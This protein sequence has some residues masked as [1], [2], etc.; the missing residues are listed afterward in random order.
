MIVCYILLFS[1][2]GSKA[3]SYGPGAVSKI[4]HIDGVQLNVGG[5]LN[6]KYA[7]VLGDSPEVILSWDWLEIYNIKYKGVDYSK[8]NNPMG[9]DLG[10]LHDGYWGKITVSL[11]G[12]QYLKSLQE[13]T[14]TVYSNISAKF[15]FERKDLSQYTLEERSE[16]AKKFRKDWLG[17]FHQCNLTLKSI[18]GSAIDNAIHKVKMYHDKKQREEAKR[19]EEEQRKKEEA[20]R[21]KEEERNA[22][23]FSASS[24]FNTSSEKENSNGNASESDQNGQ[25][26]E[27]KKEDE[28]WN[29]DQKI[30][31]SYRANR[32]DQTLLGSSNTQNNS[33]SR[34]DNF[35]SVQRQ[36]NQIVRQ[37]QR[38]AQ[39]AQQ[40]LD[41]WNNM[42]ENV[43]ASQAA[44]MERERAEREQRRREEEARRRR[45]AAIAAERQRRQEEEWR[46]KRE[47]SNKQNSFMQ[48]IND[49][50]IPLDYPA[51]KAFVLFVS[52][53]GNDKVIL[54]PSLVHKRQ[55]GRMPFQQEIKNSVLKRDK[56]NKVSTHAVYGNF[57]DLRSE[58]LRLVDKS[59]TS[60]VG[61]DEYDKFEYGTASTNTPTTTDFWGNKTE[62]NTP[63]KQ[64]RKT[65]GDFWG[66][67]K[68]KKTVN[69]KA[70]KK[71]DDDFW[72]D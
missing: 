72:K 32:N 24:S 69:K 42:W 7:I 10:P 17:G 62:G 22:R 61:V 71:T 31:K 27:D 55:D 1:T 58:M 52:K 35:A 8:T 64:K 2:V 39:Q 53:I 63:A 50:G 70:N 15:M 54:I 6:I 57:K 38:N 59:R 13:K 14:H 29:S 3:Q 41:N 65:D 40:N 12:G 49:V 23:A 16:I 18:D 45:E 26:E 60:H 20:K 36:A 11:T 56:L 33:Y 68:T 44:Q 47:I 25:D 43:A 67:S 48:G 9:I 21:K 37:A 51:D 19:K 4:F 34:R 30:T 5:N 28:A 46:K 66:A